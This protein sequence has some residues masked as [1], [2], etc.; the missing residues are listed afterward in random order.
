MN[1]EP[2]LRHGQARRSP[3]SY[4]K[5]RGGL[6]TEFVH[7]L[8]FAVFSLLLIGAAVLVNDALAAVASYFRGWFSY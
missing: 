8:V 7:G 2:T 4:Q 5:P 3:H 6:G 1:S